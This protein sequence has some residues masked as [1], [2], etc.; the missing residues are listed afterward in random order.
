[1]SVEMSKFQELETLCSE[2]GFLHAY[3]FLSRRDCTL[4]FLGGLKSD[5]LMHLFGPER[6]IKTEL[7]TLHG[8]ILKAGYNT[9]EIDRG[10][11][12]ELVERAEK[13]LSEIHDE[14]KRS[15]YSRFTEKNMQLS[16]SE[17]FSEPN[18][19]RESIFYSAEQA[20][21]FQFSDLALIRYKDDAQWLQDNMGFSLDDGYLI[22]NAIVVILN[23]NLQNSV[24]KDGAKL[25]VR[26]YLDEFEIKVDKLV[27]KS[28]LSK[29][30]VQK[31]LDAFSTVTNDGNSEFNSIDDFNIVNAKPILNVDNKHYIFLLTSLAQS[32]Y[33]SPI[34]WMRKDKSY[35]NSAVEHRGK[36]TEEFAFK[37]LAKIF[38][39]KNV[40]LNVDIF[41]NT[42]EK[43]GEIDVLAR[44]GSKYI[45]L[46]AKSKGMTIPSR[47]G[48]VEL[49]KEDFAKGFQFAYDQAIECSN[50]MMNL[51]VIFKDSDGNEISFTDKP[52]IC[53]PI[54]L[55]SESYPSLTFQCRQ[56][57]Q[58]KKQDNLNPPFIMDVFFLDI[59]TE[60]LDSPLFLLSYIDR[61]SSYIDSVM[62]STEIVLLSMHLKKNLWLDE[63]KINLM[64]FDD[65]VASDLDAAF[66]VRR[67]G[68]PGQRT[69]LGLLQRYSSGFIGKLL[70]KIHKVAK[71][72]VIDFGFTLL[73]LSGGFLDTLD[74][75]VEKIC[76]LTNQDGK[77][78]DFT[79]LFD[80]NGGG[81]TIHTSSGDSN[82]RVERILAHMKMRKYTEKQSQWTGIIVDPGSGMVVEICHVK[83]PW[84]KD[85][86]MDDAVN[87]MRLSNFKK[88]DEKSLKSQLKFKLGRNDKC[89]CGSGKKYKKCCAL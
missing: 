85:K 2:R 28:K 23:E 57:L 89:S 83:F 46:Q 24:D 74:A 20:F 25:E 80:K 60:F 33:E 73:K 54:C 69:P 82:Q 3:S 45:I 64:H 40:F 26:T 52:T 6:L 49:V 66:M 44:F 71:D 77:V 30:K 48:Q 76:Y 55:T 16:M 63:N 65:D 11:I 41:K 75:A 1:M 19:I 18:M 12:I 84:K 21:E 31:F 47:K 68:I 50:A 35:V 42:S 14:L 4:G 9:A 51:A 22:Y 81:I 58:Y 34:F 7:S 53:Y 61:R 56:H 39:E 79:T 72:D 38:G 15:Y 87:T 27:E 17:F 86:V 36:F 59:L 29:E 88:R 78:H 43:I 37:K 67:L 13:L 32:L 70:F 8:L 10:K 5:D 62:A